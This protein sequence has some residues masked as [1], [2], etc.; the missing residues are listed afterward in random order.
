M[1]EIEKVHKFVTALRQADWRA[2]GEVVESFGAVELGAGV[3]RTA[4]LLDGWVVK[5]PHEGIDDQSRNER[6]NYR[7][8]RKRPT[9]DWRLPVM[10]FLE[11]DDLMIVIAKFVDGSLGD[12]YGGNVENPWGA[13]DSHGHNVITTP[14]G[15]NYLI[16]LGYAHGYSDCWWRGHKPDD[17]GYCETCW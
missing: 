15:I 4:Y 13:R 17:E 14:N 9:P 6:K 8:M 2:L 11:V 3:E 5:Y 7:L 1:I 16:D 10:K 12:I